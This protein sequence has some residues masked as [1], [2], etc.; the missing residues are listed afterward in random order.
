MFKN[1]L[2][3]AT[4][5]ARRYGDAVR[6]GIRIQGGLEHTLDYPNGKAEKTKKLLPSHMSEGRWLPMEKKEGIR[7]VSEQLEQRELDLTLTI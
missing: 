1:S 4:A 7:A 5:L 3:N 6:E 2:R